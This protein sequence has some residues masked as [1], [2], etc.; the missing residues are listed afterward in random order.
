MYRVL[1]ADDEPIERK[2]VAK[3]LDKHFDNQLELVSVANGR[4]AI[5]KFKEKPTHLVILDIEM[6][7]INGLEAA[8]VIRRLDEHVVIVFLTAFDEFAYAKR[9]LGVQALDYL[10]K[11]ALEE[12]LIAV[13]EI[14]LGKFGDFGNKDTSETTIT[15]DANAI[16]DEAEKSLSYIKTEAIKKEV[17]AYIEDNY[18]DDISLQNIAGHMRY[19]DAYFCNMFKHCFEKSFTTYLSEFRIN[20]AKGLLKDVTINMKNVSKEVGFRDSNYF[21]RVFK[22]HIGIT[23]SEYRSEVLR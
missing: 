9:A 18:R 23:P 12:E 14:A 15:V 6:P 22:R 11:P 8:E 19:S 2:A 17:L 1:I 4:E 20:K 21:A 7:G 10:L 5:E 3:T 16:T 13:V